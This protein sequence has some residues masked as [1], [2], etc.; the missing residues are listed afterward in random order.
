MKNKHIIFTA[1][2]LT[3]AFNIL[4]NALPLAGNSTRFVSDKFF[5]LIT[6][7]PF[8][9]MIWGVIYLT[10]LYLSFLTFKEK[11]VVSS[12]FAKLFALS[13]FL[14]CFWLVMWHTLNINFSVP[15][16]ILLLASVTL[17][18]LE[19]KK[20]GNSKLNLNIFAI[21]LGWLI[22]A[23]VANVSSMLVA[24]GFGIDT[25]L[26]SISP[27]IWRIAILSV[28]FLVNL[29]FLIRE[30]V[31]TPMIVLLWAYLGIFVQQN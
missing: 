20:L 11:L 19:L 5:T 14:N 29:A 25:L 1:A 31:Y 8:T 21:Y 9:F 3:I 24:N 2:V 10:W 30:K 6:P 15:V 26:L 16:I 12:K 22:V 28:A 13:G 23:S 27:Y 18:Y 4:A 17:A 7:A